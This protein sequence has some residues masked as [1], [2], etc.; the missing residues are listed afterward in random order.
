MEITL[1]NGDGEEYMAEEDAL[2]ETNA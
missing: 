1:T 2:F